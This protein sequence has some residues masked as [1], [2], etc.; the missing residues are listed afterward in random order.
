M[1]HKV[2]QVL[3]RL[4]RDKQGAMLSVSNNAALSDTEK[5]RYI[6]VTMASIDSLRTAIYAIKALPLVDSDHKEPCRPTFRFSTDAV[7]VRRKSKSEAM[8]FDGSDASGDAI[9]KWV[10]GEA[11]HGKVRWHS[12][13][14]CLVV[15]LVNGFSE[16]LYEGEWIVKNMDGMFEILSDKQFFEQF[17]VAS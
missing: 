2:I 10:N 12:W 15:A 14:S 11:E 3:E 17:E 7:N 4:I 1:I 16:F 8:K 6:S 9:M 13:R 5:S